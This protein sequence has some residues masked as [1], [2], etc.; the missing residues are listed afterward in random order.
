M[1]GYIHGTST[2][3]ADYEQL[4]CHPMAL[5]TSR[6]NQ[7]ITAGDLSMGRIWIHI[8]ATR[9]GPVLLYSL[10]ISQCTPVHSRQDLHTPPCEASML[11]AVVPTVL[12]CALLCQVPR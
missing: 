1:K 6:L 7:A 3:G 10:D 11:F 4:G 12:S 5:S 9:V 8:C 2:L